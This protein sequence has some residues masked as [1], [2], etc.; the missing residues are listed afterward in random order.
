MPIVRRMK[1]L[2]C[3]RVDLVDRGANHD[4]VTNDGSHI[5]I[6]KRATAMSDDQT[7]EQNKIIKGI[8]GLLATMGL[9][10]IDLSKSASPEFDA[11]MIAEMSDRIMEDIYLRM[12]ALRTALYA[13][14]SGEN[15]RAAMMAAVKAFGKSV[16]ESLAGWF[17][18]QSAKRADDESDE[19]RRALLL[20]AH[21]S[22]GELVNKRENAQGD[23][24]MADKNTELTGESIAKMVADAMAAQLPVAL[25]KA[26]E[27]LNAANA[28]LK[29]QLETSEAKAEEQRQIAKAEADQRVL[30]ECVSFAKS[31]GG[32]AIKVDTD[33]ALLKRVSE[34]LDKSDADRIREILKSASALVS[35]GKVFDVIG[36]DADP[37][38]D[39]D[40]EDAEKAILAK[41]AELRAADTKLDVAKSVTLA[42]AQHP[43]LVAKA[44][45]QQL[46]RTGARVPR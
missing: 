16:D 2:E 9:P 32:L 35:K 34:K 38:A 28:E 19:E 10:L 20:K 46:R 36:R 29:K 23:P 18:E 43:E 17:A 41:A 39:D 30:G 11:A 45:E 27:P 37:A 22:M 40:A 4:Y 8:N 31:L 3:N 21:D 13:G 42:R 5:L 6:A 1:K 14:M 12:S 44:R 7:G 15:P 25:A 26:V 33:A 24:I